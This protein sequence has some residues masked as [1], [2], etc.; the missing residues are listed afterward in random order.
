MD[1]IASKS[2]RLVT[3]KSNDD[4]V[5]LCQHLSDEGPV[6]QPNEKNYQLV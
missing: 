4:F 5:A 2:E 6:E 3:D 1:K